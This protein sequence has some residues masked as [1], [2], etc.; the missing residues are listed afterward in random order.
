MSPK[1][2]LVIPCCNVEKY[3]EQS[4]RSAM[5][6]TLRDIEIICVNDGST[7]STLSIL[8]KLAEEDERIKII[9]KPN[10]G[11]GN[12]MN[13]GFDAARGEYIGILESD[14]FIEENM[15]ELH[16]Y[17]AKTNDVEVVKS[18]FYFYWSTPTE[19]NVHCDLLDKEECD[20]DNP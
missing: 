2:S 4:V 13:V 8:Q 11:Y 17:L 9:D 20:K 5:N 15:L 18:N 3:V 12:S 19:K 6:Q 7:D 14:D 1:I 10:S 16:Y